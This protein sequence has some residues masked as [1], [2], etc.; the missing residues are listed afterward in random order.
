M[1][2]NR[3]QITLYN[4]VTCPLEI[5]QLASLLALLSEMILTE[6]LLSSRL[7]CRLVLARYFKWKYGINNA[8]NIF[9]GSLTSTYSIDA[10]T[11]CLP[12]WQLSFFK[13]CKKK[14]MKFT[15]LIWL[16][17]KCQ[18]RVLCDDYRDKWQC[19][20]VSHICTRS[21]ELQQFFQLA[22]LA[23][24]VTIAAAHI[25]HPPFI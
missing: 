15:H 7:S 9:S 22:Q 11:S 24:G 4:L 19:H 25:N 20:L 10:V 23:V 12:L 6:T 5:T 3:G 18:N 17:P 21:S 1:W 2:S 14:G 16:F 8:W 13:P